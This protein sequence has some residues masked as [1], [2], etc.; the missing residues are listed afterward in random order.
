MLEN[1]FHP[2]DI[3]DQLSPLTV[4]LC[5]RAMIS[6]CANWRVYGYGR[7]ACKGFVNDQPQCTCHC[8]D[9]GKMVSYTGMSLHRQPYRKMVGIRV[10]LPIGMSGGPW[11]PEAFPEATA[12]CQSIVNEHNTHG[13]ASYSPQF[14]EELLTAVN[15][16]F[17]RK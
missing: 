1:L 10:S 12:G 7:C 9:D 8:N 14:T 2:I 4:H 3:T 15:I 5:D 11:I 16:P 17:S 13:I 6:N